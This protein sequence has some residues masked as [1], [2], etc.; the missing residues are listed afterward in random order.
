MR[1]QFQIPQILFRALVQF[2]PVTK[3][4]YW[5]FYLDPQSFLV[6]Y[7]TIITPWVPNFPM[8][9][10]RK[11]RSYY[12]DVILD[13]TS[14]LGWVAVKK[15]SDFNF[16]TWYEIFKIQIK[17]KSATCSKHLHLHLHHKM[18]AEFRKFQPPI[19]YQALMKLFFIMLWCFTMSFYGSLCMCI[20]KLPI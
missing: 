16:Y 4:G 6:K 7:F 9:L 11:S 5:D 14:L 2:F 17:S 18:A 19:M 10:L 12:N 1:L 15:F 13:L 3:K 8:S 20:R